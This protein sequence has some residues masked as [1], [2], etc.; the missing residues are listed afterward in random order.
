M[1][2]ALLAIESHRGLRLQIVATGMH[3]DRS[4]GNTLQTIG[5]E[6]WKVDEVVAWKSGAPTAEATG[7]AM[8]EL[9]S[10]FTKLKS[11]VVL[12]VGD[13]VEAFAA[14]AAGTIG[15]RVVAHVHGGDRALGQ[16]DDSLR[17]AIAKLAHVHFPATRASAN[18]LIKLG[19]D[20][21]RIHQVG[22]PGIDGIVEMAATSREVEK[23][24]PALMPRR[25]G[26]IV[27]HPIDA[28][29]KAEERRAEA[30]LKG[31]LSAGVEQVVLIYPNNDPGSGGII[32]AWR[33]AEK[34]SHC[35]ARANV[36]RQI[37]LGLLRDAAVLAGNSSSGIIEAASFKTPVVD[38]GP[39]Q[40]GRE[41]AGDVRHTECNAGEIGRAVGEIWN[42]GRPLRARAGNPYGGIDGAGRRMAQVL[43]RLEITGDLLKKLIAY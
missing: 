34:N 33:A 27:L 1:R 19:E 12:V 13:R 25:Y 22:S 21:W 20:R 11:D 38:I 35:M 26:L 6:G 41:R 36:P 3:C 2:S 23:F 29:E 5:D 42:K 28:D 8:A 10:V 7:R 40:L 18:R 16:V 32:R 39:R 30:V 37:F 24:C 9:A 43:G 15:R 31:V 14:A 17:H 4:R